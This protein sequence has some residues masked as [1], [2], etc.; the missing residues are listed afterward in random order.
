MNQIYFFF[1]CLLGGTFSGCFY[2]ILYIVKTFIKG[3]KVSVSLD[4]LFFLVFAVI[5]I[6]LSVLFELPYFRLYMFIA[7]LLGLLL[8]LESIH[9]I[10]AFFVKKLYNK[11]GK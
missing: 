7:C 8:Y 6:F 4:I 2:D 10:V 5:Y 1:V 9:R 3:K 11:L